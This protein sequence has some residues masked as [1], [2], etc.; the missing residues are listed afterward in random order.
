M[1]S[2]GR[3]RMNIYRRVAELCAQ[4]NPTTVADVLPH[5]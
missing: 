2:D 3:G 4:L 5:L 1:T